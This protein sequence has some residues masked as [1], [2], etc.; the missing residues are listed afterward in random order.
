MDVLNSSKVNLLDF[1]F[2]GGINYLGTA[3]ATESPD[4]RTCWGKEG[5]LYQDYRVAAFGLGLA[6]FMLGDGMVERAGFDLASGAGH[7]LIAT[8]TVRSAAI[9]RTQ[10]AQ[11]GGQGG[12]QAQPQGG[13]R[14][15]FQSPIFDRAQEAVTGVYGLPGTFR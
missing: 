3:K 1:A 6:S 14:P 5:R 15:L 12:G 13:N 7:S 8:E 11:G 4:L 9:K 10:Q 2:A